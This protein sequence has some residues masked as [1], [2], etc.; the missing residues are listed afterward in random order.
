MLAIVDKVGVNLVSASRSIFI[1][2]LAGCACSTHAILDRLGHRWAGVAAAC[3]IASSPWIF[4]T[5]GMETTLFLGVFALCTYLWVAGSRYG[6]GVA[7]A[8]LVL[9]RPDGIVLVALIIAAKWIVDRRIPGRPSLLERLLQACGPCTPSRRS[10]AFCPTRSRPRLPRAGLGYSRD[11]SGRAL[12]R[13]RHYHFVIVEAIVTAF[14]VVGV[15]FVMR[16]PELR[17]TLGVVAA[18]S[19][20]IFGHLWHSE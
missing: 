20:I 6:L 11:H 13:Y 19:A 4:I 9:V 3:L 16:T 14:G 8:A 10:A 2:G 5:R 17:L 12:S 7:L 1:I 15:L 18:S